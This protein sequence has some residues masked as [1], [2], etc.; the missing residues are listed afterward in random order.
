M[1]PLVGPTWAMVTTVWAIEKPA[2]RVSA[3]IAIRFFF[4]KGELRCV[5]N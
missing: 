4:M 3:A 2:D 5:E 1:P